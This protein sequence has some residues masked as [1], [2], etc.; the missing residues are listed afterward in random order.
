M[1]QFIFPFTL[2]FTALSILGAFLAPQNGLT[3][4]ALLARV[5]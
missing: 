1:N 5:S 2:A 4:L 3:N